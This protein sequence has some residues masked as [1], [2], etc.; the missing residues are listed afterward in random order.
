MANTEERKRRILE[1]VE[2]TTNT[3]PGS[4]TSDS[5]GRKERVMEH[6]NR[7]RG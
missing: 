6:V 4:R 1:H 3:A 2:R 5:R 7:T